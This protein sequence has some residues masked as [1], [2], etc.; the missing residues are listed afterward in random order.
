MKASEAIPNQEY[1]FV[2]YG[3]R[4]RAFFQGPLL[5]GQETDISKPKSFTF[6]SE[7][8]G[9]YYKI[10]ASHPVADTEVGGLELW[11]V[12]CLEQHHSA[13]FTISAMTETT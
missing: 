5:R 7:E 13:Q 8:D 6:Y 11:S 1:W 3:M 4:R 12:Y 2:F 9:K 10:A